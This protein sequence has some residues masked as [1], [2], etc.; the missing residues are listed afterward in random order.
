MSN[1]LDMITEGM[2]IDLHYPYMRVKVVKIT[3]AH[4][5]V[6]PENGQP[7]NP[8]PPGRIT[9][10]KVAKIRRRHMIDKIYPVTLER[11][12]LASTVPHSE[13]NPWRNLTP[14][15]VGIRKNETAAPPLGDSEYLITGPDGEPVGIVFRRGRKWG[16]YNFDETFSTRKEAIA[17]LIAVLNKIPESH[18]SPYKAALER[19]GA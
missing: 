2:T 13:P 1:I 14:S 7:F 18:V 9:G 8:K 11:M 4:F 17:A 3:R 15:E 16:V 6:S 12:R 10:L 5:Y 19:A